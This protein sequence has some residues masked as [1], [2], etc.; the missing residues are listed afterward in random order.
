MWHTDLPDTLAP[1]PHRKCRR[2]LF[3]HDLAPE[4]KL[5]KIREVTALET[6]EV[7]TPTLTLLVKLLAKC[8]VTTYFSFSKITIHIPKLKRKKQS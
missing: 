3:V 1:S 6:K 8:L 5:L 2:G 4:N 7:H